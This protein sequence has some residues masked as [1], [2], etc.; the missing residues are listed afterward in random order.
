[1][2]CLRRRTRGRAVRVLCSLLALVLLA[3]C[4]RAPLLRDADLELLA[5]QTERERVL[6]LQQNWSFSGRVAVSGGGDGGSGRIEWQQQGDSFS[7]SL[8]APV[9]RQ[10]WRLTAGEGWARLDGVEQGPLEG[11]D[12]EALLAEAAG[13]SMPLAQLRAWVRGARAEAQS[14][15]EFDAQ[16]LP[17]RLRQHGWQIEYRGWD[18][19]RQPPLPLRVFAESGERRVR[20]VVDRWEPEGG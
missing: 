19:R 1:M 16:G 17:A 5:A 4:V 11:S 10:S 20:L 7:V 2:S 12:A 9:S 15:L 3:G 6:A 13:W 8:S 18:Q 14:Q